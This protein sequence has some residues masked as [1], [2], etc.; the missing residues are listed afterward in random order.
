MTNFNSCMLQ[1]YPLHSFISV[2][3]KR[4]SN[5]PLDGFGFLV[6]EVE[7]LKILGTLFSSTL[8]PGRAPDGQVLLTTF[9]GGE[10]N[11]ALANL[12]TS[13]ISDP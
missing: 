4:I 5:I 2:L 13:S 3:K 6:P 8:F 10:R 1:H 9:V 12:P 7:N 11:P